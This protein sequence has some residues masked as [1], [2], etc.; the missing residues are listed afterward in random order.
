MRER[1]GAPRHQTQDDEIKRPFAA[2]RAALAPD[3]WER[4]YNVG[5]NMTIE[6]ALREA[7]ASPSSSNRAGA[8][9]ASPA[10][11]R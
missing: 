6:D 8:M 9:S 4:E 7:H 1:N 5:Q 11:A 10:P 2:A 3:V